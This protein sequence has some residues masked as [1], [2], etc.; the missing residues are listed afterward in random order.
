MLE[1]RTWAEY[2]VCY[3][4][5]NSQSMIRDG[6]E[7]GNQLKKANATE[8]GYFWHSSPKWQCPR[9]LKYKTVMPA[10]EDAAAR[11]SV[12]VTCGQWSR[13]LVIERS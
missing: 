3:A 13:R 8:I 2:R 11:D 12:A 5:A 9:S 7:I 6:I 1:E 10:E 4:A